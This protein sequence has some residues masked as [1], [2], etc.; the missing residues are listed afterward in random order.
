[1]RHLFLFFAIFMAACGHEGDTMPNQIYDG[2]D[3]EVFYGPGAPSGVTRSR[4]YNPY[5]IKGN[6]GTPQQVLI[7]GGGPSL[8]S[9]VGPVPLTLLEAEIEG[10]SDFASGLVVTVAPNGNVNEVGAK[11]NLVSIQTAIQFS[12]G[13]S[14]MIVEGLEARNGYSINVPASWVRVLLTDVVRIAGA[15]D[16]DFFMGA[17][18][19]LQRV[20]VKNP[21]VVVV[22]N[23]IAS[24]AT[25]PVIVV[26]PFA[27]A[28]RV[29]RENGAAYTITVSDGSS[30]VE[31]LSVATNV[32]MAPL[33]I[34]R[35][36]Q[37]FI[38]NDS[39]ALDL[40]TVLF[41]IEI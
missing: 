18:A 22:P 21:P 31:N 8:L 35:G 28:I 1:M 30:V 10:G 29:Q 11:G 16:L 15:N 6:V 5:R 7:P 27:R 9:E 23:L 4:K 40:F 12:S 19:T 2:P 37:V 20:P 14:Q 3:G 41:E 24:L 26:P 13:G 39:A 38:T 33:P 25:S 34:G 32:Q 17:Y 36:G